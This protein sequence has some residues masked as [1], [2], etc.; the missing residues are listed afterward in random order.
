[1]EEAYGRHL[2]FGD[3]KK[4]DRPGIE[5][6]QQAD[7]SHGKQVG[8]RVGGDITER[9]RA[10]VDQNA[11]TIEATGEQVGIEVEGTIG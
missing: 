2:P 6:S 1:M 4:T 11:G 3:E 10:H 9:G 7:L 8:M 5:V